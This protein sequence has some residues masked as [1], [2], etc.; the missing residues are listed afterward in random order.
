MGLFKTVQKMTSAVHPILTSNRKLF[1]VICVRSIN[2]NYHETFITSIYRVGSVLGIIL[3]DL[4]MNSLKVRRSISPLTRAKHCWLW[5][6]LRNVVIH[7]NT[8]TCK[9]C[10]NSTA[11]KWPFLDFLQIILV[12]K[13][14]ALMPEIGEFCKKNYGVTFQMFEK[15]SVKGEDQHPL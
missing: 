9:S 1:S 12:I 5:T 4:K 11:A 2:L 10:M 7:H 6:W 8:Q 15:L 14:P 13:N 3:Y